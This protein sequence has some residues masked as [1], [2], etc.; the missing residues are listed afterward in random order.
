[1][2][3]SAAKQRVADAM[4]LLPDVDRV[5]TF[6]QRQDEYEH[7]DCEITL[8]M[9]GPPTSAR[10]IGPQEI[11]LAVRVLLW[12]YSDT[13][14][15]QELDELIDKLAG[16]SPTDSIMGI[17]LAELA[18]DIMLDPQGVEVGY[19]VSQSEGHVLFTTLSLDVVVT[20][21]SAT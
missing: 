7:G 17:L 5:F 19:M 2:S 10:L 12:S 21:V 14:D 13:A 4:A 6:R 9:A 1:M 8:D 20:A 18:G 11:Q 3:I 16:L 15:Y